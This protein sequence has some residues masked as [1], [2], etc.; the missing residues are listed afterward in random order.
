MDVLRNQTGVHQLAGAVFLHK[1]KLSHSQNASS[2]MPSIHP[3]SGGFKNPPLHV[4]HNK[5]SP[6]VNRYLTKSPFKKRGFV[7]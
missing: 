4:N 7:G 1:S 2:K 6:L 5:K 3:S